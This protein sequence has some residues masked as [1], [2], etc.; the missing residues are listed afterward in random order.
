MA[1]RK[2]YTASVIFVLFV[3]VVIPIFNLEEVKTTIS[4]FWGMSRYSIRPDGNRMF[5]YDKKFNK[6]INPD[7]RASYKSGNKLYLYGKSFFGVID[8][9]EDKLI[10]ILLDT[11]EKMKE[12]NTEGERIEAVQEKERH[13]F[14]ILESS[15]ILK[16]NYN[17]RPKNEITINVY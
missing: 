6:I 11:D 4:E 10:I 14:K 5:L 1:M 2:V 3:L 9:K 15:S 12:T 16:Q 13:I 17:I 7:I 8:R